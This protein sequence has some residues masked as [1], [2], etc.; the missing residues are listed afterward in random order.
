MLMVTLLFL[1]GLVGAYGAPPAYAQ[2]EVAETSALG[3]VTAPRTAFF[4]FSDDFERD[5]L[6]TDWET[7]SSGAG[8]VE[9]N[10]EI[11]HTGAKSV[12]LG[13]TREENSHASL[14]LRVDLSNQSNVFLTFWWR[15]T[16]TAN[17]GNNGV[18]LS[19]NDG[20][21]WFKVM[22]LDG[23]AQFYMH[24]Y[25]N[26]S[27]AA[28]DRL[29]LNDHFLISLHY[30][31]G[32]SDK[33]G[34]LLVDD[35]RLTSRAQAV[36]SF[37]M[38]DVI[39]STVFSQGLHPV[40]SGAG[41]VE[42]SDED[43]HSGDYHFFL[44][45]KLEDNAS[46]ALHW[47]VDLEDQE[48]VYLDFW[49][50]ATGLADS[51]ENGIYISV[52]DGR[53]WIKIWGGLSANRQI[54]GHDIINLAAAAS[55]RGLIFNNRV[56]ISLVYA[57][58]YY[59][60]VGGLR[61][62]D[63][64]L[65]T[66]SKVIA[67]FPLVDSF[68]NP[69]FSQGSYPS[70]SGR[71]VVEMSDEASY[72]AP[73]NVFI[74]K[75]TNSNAAAALY[76]LVDLEGRSDVFLDFWWRAT[77]TANNSNNGVWISVND[78]AER[79]KI[80]NMNGNAQAYSHAVIDLHQKADEL[81]LVLNNRVLL[82]LHYESRYYDAIGGLRID[83]LRLDYLNPTP[84]P[85]SP[86]ITEVR[87]SWGS[88][89]PPNPLHIYGGD[90]VEGAVARLGT[91]VLTTTFITS[92]HV[93]A[94]APAGLLTGVYDLQLI[95]PDGGYTTLENAYTV[96]DRASMD[97]LSSQ[98]YNLWLD[99]ASPHA[100]SPGKVGLTLFRQG[101]NATLSNIKVRFYEGPPAQNKVIGEGTIPA[102]GKN[103][104]ENVAVTWTPASAG[105]VEIYAVID[106]ANA[107]AEFNEQNNQVQR[108]VQVLSP[109]LDLKT[110]HVESFTL[111]NGAVETD[112][113]T[114]RLAANASDPSGADD[115]DKLLYVELA[116]SAAADQWA[117]VRDSGWQ[118][119]VTARSNFP[120]T[121][122]PSS[123]LKHLQVWAADRAGN[124]SPA[125]YQAYIN[126]M[127]PVHQVAAGERR[128]IYRLRLQQGEKFNVR[129]EAQRGD[130]DLYIWP[131]DHTGGRPPWISNLRDQVDDAAGSAPVAGVYEVE[132]VA[133]TDAAYRLI[134]TQGAAVVHQAAMTGGTDPEKSKFTAPVL[135]INAEPGAQF[136]LPSP[137]QAAAPPPAKQ[138]V[139]LPLVRR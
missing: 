62:D 116:Y 64:R 55:A 51:E 117:P 2:A 73:Y 79:S 111:N 5:E 77:G 17:G 70:S 125:P 59:D 9:F 68:I 20:A 14:I 69:E 82:S 24:G 50:R 101:G 102:L 65:T 61:I 91:Q 119:Y 99:P 8:R 21:T 112:E 139:W 71:G 67:A 131:P 115:V 84:P 32:Y 29:T 41:I 127:P 37:P 36:A 27:E 72:S 48:D 123:G 74:G 12:F 130:P 49:W 76:W 42:I 33:I 25:L 28:K 23:N 98:P 85:N 44:G 110:P 120:W 83:D 45:K 114:I 54:Y 92:D 118:P 57:S 31:S 105:A 100:Q 103:S 109:A 75:K 4:P 96:I 56:R 6:G 13:K 88:Y 93:Q 10:T 1:H 26:L 38:S 136:A 134:V 30:E 97:D 87:P 3:Q 66:R 137:G 107:V 22:E 129:L 39:T 80:Y 132:I 18:Y 52:D 60:A 11:P 135:P 138:L 104:A 106:P 81:G 63:L 47:L 53:T 86:T 78:G 7:N 43:A 133:F 89:G 35:L 46:A 94:I 15:A 19:D 128:T 58:R 122:S 121:L 40:G 108:V 113:L 34:G 126:Y 124:I 90:L 95:N 16:K